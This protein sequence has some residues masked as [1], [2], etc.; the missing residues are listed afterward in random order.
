MEEVIYELK[1]PI[2]YSSK[3]E[4]VEATFVTMFGP[5]YKQMGSFTAIKQAF[6]ASIKEIQSDKDTPEQAEDD[7]KEL[8]SEIMEAGSVMLLLYQRSEP[9]SKVFLHA[10]KLFKD[11][12]AMIEG[13]TSFTDPLIKSLSLPD[14]EGLLGTYIANFIAPSLMDGL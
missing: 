8:D 13:E 14:F 11:G 12:G 4:K 2:E 6:M 9:I 10:E 7:K 5:T 3:G 1:Q